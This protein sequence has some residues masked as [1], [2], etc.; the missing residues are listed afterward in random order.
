ME[1]LKPRISELQNRE[2]SA[3]NQIEEVKKFESAQKVAIEG[4][5]KNL[6]LAIQAETKRVTLKMEEWADNRIKKPLKAI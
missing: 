5:A 2:K 4:F 6:N 3:A 1:S